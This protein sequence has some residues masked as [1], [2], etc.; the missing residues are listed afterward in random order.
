MGMPKKP[1]Q[2]FPRKAIPLRPGDTEYATA[3]NFARVVTSPEVAAYRVINRAENV[4]K[5]AEQIDVPAMLDQLRAE[6][7]A[8]NR[9]D[10]SQVESMLFNQATALQ[11]LFSSLCEKGLGA[12]YLNQYEAYVRMALRAQAQ[13]T[14]TLEVLA[15][16]KNPPVVI[17]KQ[18]NVTTGPQQNNF[19]V[20]SRA[21]GEIVQSQLSGAAGELLPDARPSGDAGG[22]DQALEALGEIDRAKVARG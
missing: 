3:R 5:L 4:S 11:T 17:A 13:C 14:R 19:S 2:K 9:G 15:T 12:E 22:V 1:Q 20:P 6:A 16:L 18:A 21:G 10:F 8:V 7:S